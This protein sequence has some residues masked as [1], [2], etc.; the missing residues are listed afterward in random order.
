[1]IETDQLRQPFKGTSYVFHL[2]AIPSVT[3]FVENP[4]ATQL[5]NINGTL[6]VLTAARDASVKRV[7]AA[8]SSSIYGDDPN[9]PRKE[10]RIGR[11]LL[12]YALSKFATWEYCR[13]FSQFYGFE[14]AALRYF[15]VFGPRQN[16][17]SD[18]AAVILRFS[19]IAVRSTKRLFHLIGHSSIRRSVEIG[20]SLQIPKLSAFNLPRT[21]VK[22]PPENQE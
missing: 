10:D 12:P 2:A 21:I 14:A 20:R 9:L 6:S 19:A 3:R 8:S 13:F 5:A 1:M 4:A 11:C 22:L 16:P 15:N 17:K 18:Y 7:I